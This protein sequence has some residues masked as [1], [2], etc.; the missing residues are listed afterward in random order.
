[1]QKG[2]SLL[3]A[4]ACMVI[5]IASCNKDE[6]V[7]IADP[8]Q[9]DPQYWANVAIDNI[10]VDTRG[11][12]NT[13]YIEIDSVY[14]YFQPVMFGDEYLVVATSNFRLYNDTNYLGRFDVQLAIMAHDSIVNTTI[15]GTDTTRQV[16]L[17]QLCYLLHTGELVFFQSQ[18]NQQDKNGG[19]LDYTGPDSVN[20]RLSLSMNPEMDILGNE[21]LGQAILNGDT[22]DVC[23][24]Q[25]GFSGSVVNGA[26]TDTIEIDGLARLPFK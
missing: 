19:F 23:I 1:M 5:F 21:G 7:V 14:Q 12:C 15:N 24:C 8:C 20:Y 22:T 18:M 3:L 10:N 6:D 13:A 17:Q 9:T 16:P 26:E 4:A 25:A 11:A 2:I